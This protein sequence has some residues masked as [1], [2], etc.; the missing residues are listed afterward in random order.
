MN[1]P[2][3]CSASA[4][5]DRRGRDGRVNWGDGCVG[6][7]VDLCQCA[8]DSFTHERPLPGT[9][10][11]YFPLRSP[12]RDSRPRCTSRP[13]NASRRSP[14]WCRWSIPP[15]VGC[16][17]RLPTG[18]PTLTLPLP[19]RRSG[20]CLQRS[21]VRTRSPWCLTSTRRWFGPTLSCSLAIATTPTCSTGFGITALPAFTAARPRFT[22]APVRPW[23]RCTSS[24]CGPPCLKGDVCRSPSR[25]S[26]RT[27]AGTGR[28][29]RR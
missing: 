13:W 27:S 1:G 26:P 12:R 7:A 2:W 18:R 22:L 25:E 8:S 10:W 16:M 17:R 3:P 23:M 5:G 20:P 11:R 4:G 14:V 9:R 6:Q 24:R 21:G 29:R 15:R 19:I 28:I